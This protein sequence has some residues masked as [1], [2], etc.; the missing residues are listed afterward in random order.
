MDAYSYTRVI[1]ESRTA[2]RVWCIAAG[3]AL[4]PMPILYAVPTTVFIHLYESTPPGWTSISWG[5]ARLFAILGLPL[6]AIFL[7]WSLPGAARPGLPLRS[8]VVLCILVGYN[9]LQSYFESHFYG[10]FVAR[11]ADSF[12]RQSPLI[13]SIRHLDTPLLIGLAAAALRWRRTLQ[14]NWKVLFHWG[15]FVCA[16]WAAGHWYDSIFFKIRIYVEF[17]I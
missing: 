7:A 2:L 3:F 13:W 4:A 1:F 9:P 8:I 16:L 14:P 17:G 5:E 11:I 10:E 6:T 12:S 15:L